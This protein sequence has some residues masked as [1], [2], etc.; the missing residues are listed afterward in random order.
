M[1]WCTSAMVSARGELGGPRELHAGAVS[2]ERPAG[3]ARAGRRL[4][5]A[6][7][8][9]NRLLLQRRV[10]R[11]L[12]QGGRRGAAAAWHTHALGVDCLP[13]GREEAG[14]AQ[15]RAPPAGSHTGSKKAGRPR[16]GESARTMRNTWLAAVR[17]MPTAPERMLSKN[18]AGGGHDEAGLQNSRAGAQRQAAGRAQCCLCTSCNCRVL[19]HAARETC[20]QPLDGAGRGQPA[21]QK[22]SA[23]GVS[24]A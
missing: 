8:A 19:R 20:G 23:A 9:A 24:D 2:A 3:F 21:R 5:H 18:T 11:G 10:Q 6:P 17:L 12:L 15:P 14:R 13:G 7:G 16:G 22:A 4:T 1:R